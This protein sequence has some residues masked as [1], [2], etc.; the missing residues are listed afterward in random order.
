MFFMSLQTRS[1]SQLVGMFLLRYAI[2][3]ERVDI[4]ATAGI[5]HTAHIGIHMKHNVRT[6]RQFPHVLSSHQA[7]AGVAHCLEGD[8][9]FRTD[10]DTLARSDGQLQFAQAFPV[11]Q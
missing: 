10:A 6:R 7:F 2:D 4:A 5:A 1:E 3:G 9:A 11:S 8:V